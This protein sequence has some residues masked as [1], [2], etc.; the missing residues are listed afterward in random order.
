MTAGHEPSAKMPIYVDSSALLKRYIDEPDSEACERHLLAD[1][2]WLTARHTLVEVRRNLVRLL[3]GEALALTREQLAHDWRRFDV[4]ELDELTCEIAADIAEVTG[5]R[6]LDALH[7]AAATRLGRG[8]LPFLTY[9][10]RQAQA[11]RALGFSV[12]GV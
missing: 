8:A 11:A 9:D 1:A 10:V 4:I 5:A 12:L 6:S 2:V 7:L 3:A